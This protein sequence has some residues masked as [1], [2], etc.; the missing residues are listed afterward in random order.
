MIP[1][2]SQGDICH[3]ID[4][5]SNDGSYMMDSELLI[6]NVRVKSGTAF[7]DAVRLIRFAAILW[8][9]YLI[10]LAI[11]SRSF[12][13]SQRTYPIYYIALAG[14]AVVCLILSYWDWIRNG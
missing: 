6:Y 14:V 5:A 8:I 11:I 13:V 2:T 10:L 7:G 9:A 12:P 3:G 1:L 4:A